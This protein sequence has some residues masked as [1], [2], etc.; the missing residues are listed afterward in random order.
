MRL[1]SFVVTSLLSVVSSEKCCE[2]VCLVEGEEKYYSID[3]RFNTCGECCMRPEDFT[4]YSKFEKGLT[5][6]NET[7][8]PCADL[9]YETYTKTETH[10]AGSVT[11][12]LDMYNPTP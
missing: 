8:T 12:T 9:K 3:T 5:A 4:L 10:G 1:L 6:A 7:V 11:M 2:G